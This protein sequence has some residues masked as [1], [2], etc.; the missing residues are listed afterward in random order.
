MQHHKWKCCNLQHW[1]LKE[2]PPKTSMT[3]KNFEGCTLNLHVPTKTKYDLIKKCGKK[4]MEE[5][6]CMAR[7]VSSFLLSDGT[8]H[9]VMKL[10]TSNRSK[11][12]IVTTG[13]CF[14]KCG[15]KC[16]PC[17]TNND[18]SMPCIAWMASCA[19]VRSKYGDFFF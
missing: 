18:G 19:L 2:Q 7:Q 12:E 13:W 11:L 8:F 16:V 4:K 5:I 9:I 15:N 6:V 3:L 10:V 17:N 1:T 14:K